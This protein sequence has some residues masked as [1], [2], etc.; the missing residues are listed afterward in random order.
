MLVANTV[1]VVPEG[2]EHQVLVPGIAA[3]VGYYGGSITT[4]LDHAPKGPIME[5]SC[6]LYLEF[7]DQ[8]SVWQRVLGSRVSF[9]SRPLHGK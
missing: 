1:L 3:A 8:P 5:L 6:K 9:C 7:A 4:Q 2:P